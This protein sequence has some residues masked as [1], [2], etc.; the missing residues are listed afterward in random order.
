[1]SLLNPITA[2]A[3]PYLGWIKFGAIA[4]ILLTSFLGGCHEQK[5]RDNAVIAKKDTALQ[6]AAESLRAAGNALNAV[7]AEAQREIAAAKANAKSA[8]A[9]EGIAHQAAAAMAQRVT[10]YEKKL[11]IARKSAQCDA[12]LKRDLFKECG[13]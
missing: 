2:A 1:M 6:Q 11:E 3:A 7:N 5:L 13:L 4:A 8:K 9:A 12:L 10:G